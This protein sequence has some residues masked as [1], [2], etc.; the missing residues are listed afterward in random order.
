MKLPHILIIEDNESFRSLLAQHLSSRGHKV[1]EAATGE[2]GIALFDL[3]TVGCVL[4]DLRLPDVDGQ[5]VLTKLAHRSDEIPFIVI[6]G[7]GKL[8]DAI[9]AMRCGAWDYVVKDGAVLSEVDNALG[10]ALGR[11]A[12]IHEQREQMELVKSGLVQ[13][14]N[15]FRTLLELSP[16]PI[17]ITD[18][19]TGECVYINKRAADQFGVDYDKAEGTFSQPFY[20]SETVRKSLRTQLIKTGKLSDV[21]IELVRQDGTKFWTQ[22]SAVLTRLYSRDVVYISFSDITE[23][24][25]MQKALERFQFIANAS[26]DLM[27]LSNSS[28]EYEALNSSYLESHD[29]RS[30]D[31]IGRTMVEIWGAPTF[32]EYIRPHFDKCLSGEVVTYSAWFSFPVKEERYYD[33]SMYPYFD[34]NGKVTHVATVSRDVT[35]AAEAQAE[36]LESREHFRAIFESSVDPILLFDSSLRVVDMN[37]ATIAKFGYSRTELIGSDINKL[38]ESCEAVDDF[39]SKVKPALTGAGSWIGEWTFCDIE[40]VPIPTE[41]S[42]SVIMSGTSMQWDGYVAVM[43]DI[44]QRIRA[45]HEQIKIEERYHAMFETMGAATVIV[46][47]NGLISNANQRFVELSGYERDNIIDTLYWRE[48]VGDDVMACKAG[49]CESRF[50]PRSG[51][52]RYVYLY[53]DEIQD[54]R[55]QIMSVVDITDRKRAENKLRDALYEMEAIQQNTIIGIGL[56]HGDMVTRLNPRGAEIFGSTPEELAGVRP[57]HFFPSKGEFRVFQVKALAALSA[58]G[59]YE[60]EQLFRRDD[61]TTVWTSLFAK[62]VDKD[63]LDQ[64]IIWTILD[65]T[66]RRYNEVVANMLYR[67]SN[68]VNTTSDVDA[69]YQRIHRVLDDNLNA[70]NFFVGLLNP[71]RTTLE[72]TYFEDEMDDFKGRVF[73]LEDANA[74]SLSVEV[75]RLERPLIVT[76]QPVGEALGGDKAAAKFKYMSRRDFLAGK[77]V[78]ERAMAG[79]PSQVWLGVPLKIKGEVIGVMA[80]QSYSNPYQYTDRDVELLVS[81]SEQIASALERK[82]IELDLVTAKE[83]AESANHS[84]SEFLANMSHEVRTPLNGV[85]GMLQLAQTTDLNEEQRDYVD[86]ALSSG[87]SLLS[88]INDILDFSKIEAGKMEVVQEPFSP[89]LLCSDVMSAF[90]AQAQAKSLTL[91]SHVDEDVPEVVVGGKGRLKQ[92]LF[93][94]V[95]NGLKFTDSGGVSVLIRVQTRSPELGRI[96]LLIRV[97]DTGIGIPPDKIDAIFEP[98]TQVDGSYVRQHQGTGLGLGIVKRLVTLMGGNLEIRSDEGEGTRVYLTFDFSYDSG[99]ECTSADYSECPLTRSDLNLLVVEDN[100]VN[101][102]LAQRMLLK[103]GYAADVVADGHDALNLLAEREYDGVFMD[104]QMPGLDGVETTRRI[105]NAE[106]GSGIDPKVKVIAMTAHA[107]VGDREVFLSGGMDDYVAKPVEMD[108][109]R[110]VLNRLF[111]ETV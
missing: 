77:G 73:K 20:A 7:E 1:I 90:R 99:Q 3:D 105:R 72:F 92:V 30:E 76:Q 44:S 56:F 82:S 8:D 42:F 11:A 6:S 66:E 19:E 51:S 65:I 45:E 15:R 4:V 31:I 84:K 104:I 93:N 91:E 27:T 107:M 80:V 41:T 17:V 75:V 100:R 60:T 21:D 46:E 36:V 24:K 25:E 101:R 81:V 85:L 40:G 29:K 111:P 2:E 53:A 96:R 16:L 83:L 59:T 69:L 68:A 28:Y 26:H 88:V 22:A 74:T 12:Y 9:K 33:V 10:K 71:D 58:E 97:S 78:D 32:E 87:R 62:A 50:I 52:L 23:R 5:D 63:D 95:G 109:I 47:E 35:E 18:L 43:R 57:S 98:F 110:A 54:T 39:N 38:H 55:Q 49:A 102:I 48:F 14:E 37:T 34:S 64:G 106:P 103:L 67:I 13:S 89:Q 108:D 79:N 94:L 86:T 61:G 70:A